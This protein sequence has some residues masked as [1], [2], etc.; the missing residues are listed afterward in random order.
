M[1]ALPLKTIL[2]IVKQTARNVGKIYELIY[3]YS[4]GPILKGLL[5]K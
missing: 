1:V 5:L 3:Y 2:T 4:Y